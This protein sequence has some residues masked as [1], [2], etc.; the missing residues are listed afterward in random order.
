MDG[1]NKAEVKDVKTDIQGQIE[2]ICMFKYGIEPKWED[3]ANCNGGEISF[4]CII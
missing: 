3:K 1:N 4:R 2:A